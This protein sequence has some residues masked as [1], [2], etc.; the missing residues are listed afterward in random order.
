MF[1]TFKYWYHDQNSESTQYCEMQV[2][3]YEIMQNTEDA[4]LQN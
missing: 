1:K 4:N 2:H 3:V